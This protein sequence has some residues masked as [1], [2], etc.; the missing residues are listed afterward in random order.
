MH[1][2]LEE[3]RHHT[4]PW[5]STNGF[6]SIDYRCSESLNEA[7]STECSNKGWQCLQ[8]MLYLRP[9]DPRSLTG[10][11]VKRYKNSTPFKNPGQNPMILLLK[12]TSDSRSSIQLMMLHTCHIYKYYHD[13]QLPLTSVTS[14]STQYIT[15]VTEIP[16]HLLLCSSQ[17]PDAVVL[18]HKH[19]IG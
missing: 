1:R 17:I 15:K 14:I 5:S 6:L 13:A 10:L 7:A 9:E 3:S 11:K 8:H 18:Q 16:C 4:Q 12:S 19:I 2:K